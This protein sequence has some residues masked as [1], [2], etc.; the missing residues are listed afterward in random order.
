MS[1][2]EDPGPVPPLCRPQNTALTN[3]LF[4]TLTRNNDFL[5]KAMASVEA[6]PVE[7]RQSRAHDLE[8][9]IAPSPSPF[10]SPLHFCQVLLNQA[11]K[12]SPV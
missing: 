11:K 5:E 10:G 12:I 7:A 4:C 2:K 6:H 3:P 8:R 9:H 1:K